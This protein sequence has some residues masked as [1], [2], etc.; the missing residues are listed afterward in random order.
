[1][2]QPISDSFPA[3]E[4]GNDLF[5]DAQDNPVDKDCTQKNKQLTLDD[6]IRD[7]P[8]FLHPNPR[9]KL[10]G[11]VQQRRYA[12]IWYYVKEFVGKDVTKISLPIHLN[13]PLSVLHKAAEGFTYS[14]VLRKM[15]LA[16]DPVSRLEYLA[17][18]FAI[19]RASASFRFV[20]PFNPILGETYE[21]RNY[22]KG[23]HFVCEQVSHH[24]PIIAVYYEL[25]NLRT[26]MSF[27]QHVKFWGNSADL[28]V[29]GTMV[30]EF[31]DSKGNV[32]DVITLKPP[33]TSAHNIIIG[34]LILMYSIYSYSAQPVW[35]GIISNRHKS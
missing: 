25:P 7:V 4:Y 19:C 17:A 8:Y 15:I 34:K 29:T 35:S 20:K 18:Y 6:V 12:S 3:D 10:P 30:L 31:L 2:A 16:N 26:Q 11:I 5:F 28:Y 14:G 32:E 9:E 27:Q 24:P 13:E 21:M 33:I 22:E 23:F 1:M